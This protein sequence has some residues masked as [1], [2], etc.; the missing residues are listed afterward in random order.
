MFDNLSPVTQG[1]VGLSYAIAYLTKKGYNVSVPLV[2]NQSYDLVCEIDGDLKKVQVKTTRTKENSN[3]CI[4]L[5]SIRSNRTGNNIHKF[6]NK[7]SDYLL[8]VT[9]NGDIY[10]IPTSEIEAK[11]TLSLGQKYESYKDRL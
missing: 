5:R 9:E 6:D 10:F 11:S 4:Q 8:S 2:D 3:Y 7:L 1:T